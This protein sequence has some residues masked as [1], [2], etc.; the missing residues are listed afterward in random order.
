M[1]RPKEFD[2]DARV[3]DVEV[4]STSMRWPAPIDRRLD[5]LVECAKDAGEGQLSRGE[6]VA[7]LVATAEED[8]AKLRKALEHLRLAKVRDVT[9]QRDQVGPGARVI[10][11]DARRPGRRRT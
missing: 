9:L 1:A 10:A 8:G 7:A 5:G 11:L 2:L 4:W 3:R 6:L